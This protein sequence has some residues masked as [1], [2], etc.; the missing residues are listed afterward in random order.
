MS[1]KV[2]VLVAVLRKYWWTKAKPTDPISEYVDKDGFYMGVPNPDLFRAQ[3]FIRAKKDEVAI[4]KDWPQ[5]WID[6]SSEALAD[7]L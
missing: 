2:K 5:G 1:P 3:V 4:K 6:L 7:S